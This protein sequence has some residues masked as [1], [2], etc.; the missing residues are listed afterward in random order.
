M[1]TDTPT[2]PYKATR[3]AECAVISCSHEGGFGSRS[4]CSFIYE[5][6]PSDRAS[7]NNTPF[8]ACTQGTSFTRVELTHQS[9]TNTPPLWSAI[10]Q[11]RTALQSIRTYVAIH[12]PVHWLCNTEH[13]LYNTEHWL[14]LHPHFYVLDAMDCLH[15]PHTTY[16]H[17]HTTA[18]CSV[19]RRLKHSRMV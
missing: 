16:T 3:Y 7:T 11:L 13:W 5:G 14:C 8:T 10:V 19:G 1:H 15:T 9:H 12:N 6:R 17:I 4:A 18:A 2:I